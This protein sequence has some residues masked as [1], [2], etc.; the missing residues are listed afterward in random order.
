MLRQMNTGS[1]RITGQNF[2]FKICISGSQLRTNPNYEK[3]DNFVFLKKYAVS[4]VLEVP[5]KSLDLTNPEGPK[6]IIVLEQPFIYIRSPHSLLAKR[7]RTY[8]L[9][10]K[11][12][13]QFLVRAISQGLLGQIVNFLRD[14][15]SRWAEL[16][17]KITILRKKIV[18]RHRTLSLSRFDGNECFCA[19]K[20]PPR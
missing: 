3:T 12:Y 11:C 20:L 18:L 14:R 17:R 15:V 9:F 1:G 7:A 10:S 8:S 2:S 5:G 6:F 13:P 4:L 16:I 19:N